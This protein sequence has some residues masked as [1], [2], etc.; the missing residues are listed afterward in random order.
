MAFFPCACGQDRLMANISC[1]WLQQKKEMQL[2]RKIP[3][4]QKISVVVM[5]RRVIKVW[6]KQKFRPSF[7][8]RPPEAVSKRPLL[9]W[10][11]FLFWWWLCFAQKH[12]RSLCFYSISGFAELWT[13]VARNLASVGSF[14]GNYFALF[15]RLLYTTLDGLFSFTFRKCCL[16]KLRWGKFEVCNLCVFSFNP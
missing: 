9:L 7:Y 12:F 3:V 6:N 1:K 14:V 8:C 15:D 5:W 2:S 11:F 16:D 4:H 10:L 13:T